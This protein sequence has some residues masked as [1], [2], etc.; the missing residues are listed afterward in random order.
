MDAHREGVTKLRLTHEN[1]I[2]SSGVTS[3]SIL[4]L[5]TPPTEHIRYPTG[6]CCHDRI[7]QFDLVSRSV[8]QNLFWNLNYNIWCDERAVTR[9]LVADVVPSAC[10]LISGVIMLR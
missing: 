10:P 1:M 2:N 8:G 7:N 6:C 3:E 4:N 5:Q 9:A